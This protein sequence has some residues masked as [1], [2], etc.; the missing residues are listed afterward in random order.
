MEA[1]TDIFG[2]ESG[3]KRKQDLHARVTEHN[4]LVISKY[5]SQMQISRLATLLDLSEL[6]VCSSKHQVS[7][8][9]QPVTGNDAKDKNTCTP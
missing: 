8:N 9:W 7:S 5:Y 1:M 2:G 3:G 4:I 6:E